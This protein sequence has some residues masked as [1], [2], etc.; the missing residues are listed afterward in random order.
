MS[1][2][3]GLFGYSIGKR[4]LGIKVENP[5]G[6]PIGLVRAFVRTAL[7]CLVIPALVMTATSVASTTSLRARASRRPERLELIPSRGREA[8]QLNYSS[9]AH[10]LARALHA[11]RHR[12]AAGSASAGRIAS[13]ALSR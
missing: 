13:S 2:L 8:S 3:T 1:I 10:R 9:A 12:A 4:I 6:R 11:R 7:L 5:D